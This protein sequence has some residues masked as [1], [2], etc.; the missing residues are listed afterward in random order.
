MP[1][2]SAMSIK[3]DFLLTSLPLSNDFFSLSFLT[4]SKPSLKHSS[5][6]YL[7][8]DLKS[9]SYFHLASK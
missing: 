3:S 8:L 2:I 7:I 1:Q 4:I 6:E 5:C 9:L